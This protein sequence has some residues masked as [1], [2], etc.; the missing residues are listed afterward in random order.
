MNSPAIV[1][2]CLLEGTGWA[3]QGS[4][5]RREGSWEVTLREDNE[6]ESV[7]EQATCAGSDGAPVCCPPAQGRDNE[8][9]VWEQASRAAGR[10]GATVKK[11]AD[12]NQENPESTPLKPYSEKDSHN[13]LRQCPL[14]PFYGTH[15]S[16]HI[17][18]RR[19]DKTPS[20]ISI[21]VAKS[22]NASRSTSKHK[23]A[24][25]TVNP[26]TQ[27]Y[28]CAYQNCTA[29]V[30]RK[31][32]HLK[33]H[34]KLTDPK[35]IKQASAMFRKLSG[36]ATTRKRAPKQSVSSGQKQK[37]AKAA[38]PKPKPTSKSHIKAEKAGPVAFP[39]PCFF[40]QIIPPTPDKQLTEKQKEAIVRLFKTEIE[41]G[42]KITLE[43]AQ[44]KFYMTRKKT[45]QASASH[46]AITKRLGLGLD[47]A[48]A[49][50]TV[51]DAVAEEYEETDE[52]ANEANASDREES[53]KEESDARNRLSKK[54]LTD[55]DLLF[56]KIISTNARQR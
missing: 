45:T 53:D 4:G 25:A 19:D 3:P 7:G 6:E 15:L 2:V 24:A 22:D 39:L 32:Q 13:K 37:K 30:T 36:I 48:E 5:G 55:I 43:K 28:Q 20:E 52:A 18:L 10:D 44:S 23:G 38:K 40:P 42:Q 46:K 56:S 33:R 51:E 14:C 12:N 29:V 21:L 27:S 35:E 26:N 49:D 50:D 11:S 9:E 54:Q 8:E 17:A 47:T 31:S 41:R 34:H 16:R 1:A